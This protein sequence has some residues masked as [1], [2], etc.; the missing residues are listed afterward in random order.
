MRCGLS[1]PSSVPRGMFET[2]IH[3][4]VRKKQQQRLSCPLAGFKFC[5]EDV[6]VTGP[7]SSQPIIY[8]EQMATSFCKV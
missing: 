3:A 4:F 2:Q 5:A 7:G 1:V 8:G 6:D